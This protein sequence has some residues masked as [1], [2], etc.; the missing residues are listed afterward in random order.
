[1]CE[2]EIDRERDAE[3]QRERSSRPDSLGH[4]IQTTEHQ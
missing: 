4:R 3:D 2:R 1:M